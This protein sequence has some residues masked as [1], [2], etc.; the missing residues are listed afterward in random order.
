MGLEEGNGSPEKKEAKEEQGEDSVGLSRKL[1]ETSICAPE[2]DE[3]E[4]GRKIEL[5]PQCT[6]KEQLEK[7]KVPVCIHFFLPFFRLMLCSTYND[8]MPS[9][10]GVLLG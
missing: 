5:G 6:L 3:D 8:L 10:M 4:E 1:S 7:D 9:K 2:E